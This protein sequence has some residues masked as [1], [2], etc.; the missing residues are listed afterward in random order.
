MKMTKLSIVV[1]VLAAGL[2]LTASAFAAVAQLTL[3]NSSDYLLT[4]GQPNYFILTPLTNSNSIYQLATSPLFPPKSQ[5]LMSIFVQAI[6]HNSCAP[7]RIFIGNTTVT[8]AFDGT[9]IVA[10]FSGV[11]STP[12]STCPVQ[13]VTITQGNPVNGNPSYDITVK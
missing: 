13:T 8:A 2:G 3:H 10:P 7:A 11:T 12:P 1:P 5:S 4:V 6:E 9:P